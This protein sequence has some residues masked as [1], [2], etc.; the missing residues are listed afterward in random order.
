[1]LEARLAK[2][3]ILK[4]LLDAIK[5]LVTDANFDCT[6]SGISLQAMDNSHVAL[7][8]LLLRASGFDHYRCDRNHALGISLASLGKVLK[9]AGNDDTLTI[10]SE[11]DGD[12]LQLVFESPNVDRVSEYDL[13][14]MDI[15]SEHLGIPDTAYDAVV[16][17]PSGEFQRI[18]RDLSVLSESVAIDVD[19]EGVKFS[20]VGEIGSGAIKIKQ[21]AAVDDDGAV[22]TVEMSQPVS[23]TFS[24]KYLNNFAKATPLSDTVSLNMSA[25]VPLLVEYKCSEIGYIRYYLAPKIGDDN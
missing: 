3:S 10:K 4:K 23:L 8:S 21:G 17:M 12:I 13:K 25:D 1:M 18:C 9:C 15:D 7:V 5:E 24:L 14:L 11:E 16:K 6:D 20:A 19:K 2:A 22:T